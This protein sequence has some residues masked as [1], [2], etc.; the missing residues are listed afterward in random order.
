MWT[1]WFALFPVKPGISFNPLITI[2]SKKELNV[3]Y[4]I[5]LSL[6]IRPDLVY[7]IMARHFTAIK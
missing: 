5:N 2:E 4:L 3:H 1:M 7:S 6:L